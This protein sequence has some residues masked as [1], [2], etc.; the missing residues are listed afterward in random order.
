MTDKNVQSL[1]ATGPLHEFDDKEDVRTMEEDPNQSSQP[2]STEELRRGTTIRHRRINQAPTDVQREV[3]GNL[4]LDPGIRELA[5]LPRS[6][7][8]NPSVQELAGFPKSS[9]PDAD[10]QEIAKHPHQLNSLKSN[11]LRRE[12][13]MNHQ[14][15]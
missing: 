9:L 11:D 7:L 4:L 12:A 5:E 13:A 10:I 2:T 14:Q 3:S 1:P 15:E 8:P 6:P